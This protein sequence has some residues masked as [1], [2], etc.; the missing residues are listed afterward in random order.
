MKILMVSSYLPYPLT[1]GG[2]VRLYNILKILSIN[3]QITLV[4]EKRS[5]QSKED[6]AEV[7]KFCKEIITVE[8]K[9]QW[10]INNIIKTGFSKYPFLITG[11]TFFQMKK[12]IEE[13]LR[14]EKFDL[15]HV[16][17]FYVVQNLPKTSIPIVLAEH[18][19]EYLVYKRFRDEAP[20]FVRPFLDIDIFKLKK[21]E[22]ESWRK[23][24]VVVTVSNQ[25]KKNIQSK[26]NNVFVVPNGVDINKF[27]ISNRKSQT[28]SNEK[29]VLFIGDF[30]WV[31][32]RDAARMILKDIWPEIKL[33]IESSTLRLRS[34]QELKI[35]LW[36]VGTNIPNLIK[37][38]GTDGVVFDENAPSDTSKIFEK[39]DLLLAPIRI[40]GGTS[41]KILEAMASGVPVIT[42]RLSAIG[43]GAMDKEEVLIAE[44]KEE[45]TDSIA[46]LLRDKS[47]YDKITKNARSLVEKKYD[48]ENIV[49]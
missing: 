15:I 48:W 41:F 24:S 26:N 29:T 31:E 17:T 23:A 25:D 35:K 33:K 44:S 32:N 7:R 8:R 4:C 43:I 40:G 5:Y 3:H 45:F 20:F 42:T 12:N 22:E 19:I 47:L 21:I 39:A 10:S 30:R 34:R 28:T 49:K 2:H 18:N 37:K 1:S 36:I 27:Q 38:L 13:M 11:H 14:K 46:E 9:K 16:E 6:I